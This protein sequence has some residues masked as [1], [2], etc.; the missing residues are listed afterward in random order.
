[1]WVSYCIIY[2]EVQFEITNSVYICYVSIHIA[3]CYFQ[4]GRMAIV[5]IEEFCS[6]IGYCVDK[7][8][9]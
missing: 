4:K 2:V 3:C 8:K 7:L 6:L 5:H 1:M 9:Q